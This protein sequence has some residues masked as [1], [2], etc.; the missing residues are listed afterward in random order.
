M[1]VEGLT[2]PRLIQR[3]VQNNPQIPAQYSKNASGEFEMLTYRQMW[4]KAMDFAG[5][6]LYYD[7]KR[8]EKI[9][10]I[11]EDREEWQQADIGLMAIGCVDV[12]RGTDSSPADLKYILSFTETRIVIAE[13]NTAAKKIL[14]QKAD[15]PAL[16]A[17]VMF[18][19]PDEETLLLAKDAAVKM[20]EFQEIL[21]LGHKYNSE[22][23]GAVEKE[24]AAGKWDDTAAIIF[25]SGTTGQPKGVM[26]SHGNFL[27][28]LIEV[29]DRIH[30]NPGE[31]ALCILPVWHVY[32]R[33]VEYVILSQG[34]ALTYSKPVG[35]VLLADIA[36]IN[37]VIVPGVPRVFEAIKEGVDRKMRRT[38]G[39]TL[40]LYNFFVSVAVL[41][42]RMHRRMFRQNFM[43]RSEFTPGWWILFIIPWTLLW[44]L[45]LLGN[46]LVFSK[47]KAMLGKNWRGGI[48]GG[49]AYPKNIDEY[50]WALGI[51]IVEGYGLTE[52]APIVS[53]RYMNKPVFGCIGVPLYGVEA[54]IV[55]M[56][57]NDLGRGQKGVLQ[58]KGGTVM[59]GYYKKPDLT[60]KVIDGQGW[61]DTGDL[62]IIGTGG[63]LKILGR[64]KDTIVLRGGENVEPLPIEVKLEENVY[65]QTAVVIGQDQRNLGALILPNSEELQIWA[66]DG[67]IAFDS[68]EDLITK[69]EVYKLYDSIVRD[70]VSTKNG[71]RAFEKI[72][73]FA[74]LS[75]PFEVGRELSAKQELMRYKITELYSKEVKN[76]F[77]E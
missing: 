46:A 26:L 24:L 1:N 74:L 76:I 8:G 28:Q 37:P 35:S 6:L 44:P 66:K 48:A 71:F 14:A 50:F 58:I 63:E 21:D 36:K 61:L 67:G 10:L 73:R 7:I 55:D 72:P 5:G 31:N 27:T 16:F 25:T 23:P 2:I 57:G 39:I 43:A 65:I 59:Q 29:T 18:D 30:L 32:M 41:H 38:G 22:H 17:M 11:S 53:V 47:I 34:C 13:N 54:R 64:V 40:A 70:I 3:T 49:G 42:S 19:K 51:N 9:G 20:H 33:E 52:T 68:F 56:E 62:A 75:K 4:D 69:P 45:K 12:P 15:L 60:A 77:K